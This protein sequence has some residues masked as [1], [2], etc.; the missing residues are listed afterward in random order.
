MS[1]FLISATKLVALSMSI[2]IESVFYN[3]TFKEAS[4]PKDFM[5]TALTIT[6]LS[7][8]PTKVDDQPAIGIEIVSKRGDLPEE[9]GNETHLRLAL[10][11]TKRVERM[12]CFVDYFIK[13][14]WVC[15]DK[16][17]RIE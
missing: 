10:V 3:L 6:R 7:I 8:K 15:I 16:L 2:V 12:F 4:C 9:F 11:E 13:L 5:Y 17:R 14:D 1:L